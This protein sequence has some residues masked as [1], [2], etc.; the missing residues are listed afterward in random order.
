LEEARTAAATDEDRQHVRQLEQ[1]IL[2]PRKKVADDTEQV[3]AWGVDVEKLT[4]ELK[5]LTAD[6]D[7]LEKEKTKLLADQA[8]MD[9]RREALLPPSPLGKLSTAFR[10]IPLMQFINPAEKVTQDVLPDVRTDVAFQ[11]ITTID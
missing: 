11:K 5:G 10:R 1:D 3:K 6:R 9:K 2:A 7:A 4:E 8:A